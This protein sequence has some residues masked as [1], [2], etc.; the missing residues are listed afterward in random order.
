MTL[1]CQVLQ[2]S[3]SGYYAWRKRQSSERTGAEGRLV[4]HIQAVHAASRQ[5]YGC[6]RV[7]AALR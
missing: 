5:T 7:Q 6:R 2:V 1:Q 4:A 3:E